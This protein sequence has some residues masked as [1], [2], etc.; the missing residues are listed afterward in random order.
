VPAFD[1]NHWPP[2]LGFRTRG[3]SS[4]VSWR[5]L[6]WRRRSSRWRLRESLRSRYHQDNRQSQRSIGHCTTPIFGGQP[7]RLRS[8]E[9]SQTATWFHALRQKLRRISA[10]TWRALASMSRWVQRVLCAN[11]DNGKGDVEKRPPGFS[12]GLG[13]LRRPFPI[14]TSFVVL[15]GTRLPISVLPTIVA[16]LRHILQLLLRDVSS[17]TAEGPRNAGFCP[18]SPKWDSRGGTAAW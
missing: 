10:A 12:G 8:L 15:M 5:G 17:E 18:A 11:N 7:T 14:R 3:T 13:G 6:C 16:K 4:R 1:R 2:C 9:N